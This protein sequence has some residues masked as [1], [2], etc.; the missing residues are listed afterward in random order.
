[1]IDVRTELDTSKTQVVIT[2]LEAGLEQ[3]GKVKK[4]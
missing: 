1:M 4:K 3:M 2:L